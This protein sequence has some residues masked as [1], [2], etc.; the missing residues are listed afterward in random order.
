[1]S[2]VGATTEFIQDCE[3]ELVGEAINTDKNANITVKRH[4]IDDLFLID[5]YY[6][7]IPYKRLKINFI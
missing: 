7:G 1:M 2:V 3:K 4:I 6:N 5:V